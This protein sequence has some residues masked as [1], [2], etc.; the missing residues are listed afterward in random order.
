MTLAMPAT[1][2]P[3][4]SCSRLSDWIN[5]RSEGPMP[6][7]SVL[8][9]APTAALQAP[10]GGENQLFQ[11]ARQL[12]AQGWP[13]RLMAPWADRVER[14][15]LLH[16]FGMSHEG[17][18]LARVAR[19]RR[20]PV[21]LSSI[22]WYEPRALVQLA[23]S[24]RERAVALGGWSLKR[25]APRRSSWRRELLLLADQ[26]LPNSECEAR[27]LQQLFAIDGARITVI[28]NG[29]DERFRD[30][31]PGR[32][33]DLHPGNGFVL[34]VGRIEPRKNP[35]GLIEAVRHHGWPLVVIGDPVPG[36]ESY[37]AAC[38]RAGQGFVT[39]LPRLEHDDPRLAAAYAAARV[40][41][42]PSWFETPGLAALE[43]GLAGCPVVITP[44]GCT[45][46]YFQDRVHY[47]APDDPGAIASAVRAAWDAPRQPD[48][49]AFLASRYLWREVARRTA[50]V[51]HA[52]VA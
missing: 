50:E 11:T 7:G 45:R 22:C 12:E 51:Y 44:Y 34:F 14:A 26:I 31:D 24:F 35:L 2:S 32:F 10:G 38:R 4:E 27:Q 40:F 17:L 36:H 25:L 42:L 16:L 1:A 33:A 48:L 47:A 15:S 29:V 9:H 21:V 18:A 19:A 13:V 6:S 41:A 20:I 8:M 5:A 30:A 23:G 28:P 39:W 49:S 46:E 37:A 3:H 52:I 43:A